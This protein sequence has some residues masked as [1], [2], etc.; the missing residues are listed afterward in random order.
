M[1]TLTSKT[2]EDI[3]FQRGLIVKLNPEKF[4]KSRNCVGY[5][6]LDP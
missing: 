4:H 5:L 2:Q 3:E 1:H 6:C